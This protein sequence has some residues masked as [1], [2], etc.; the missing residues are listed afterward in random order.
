MALDIR[1]I[2]GQSHR[3]LV[4]RLEGIISRLRSSDPD[5]EASLRVVEERPPTETPADEPLVRAMAAAYR[6]LTGREPR[7]NGV[8]GATDGTFL[9]EWAGIPVVTTGAGLREIPHHAD[10]WVGLEELY[11]TCRLYAASA[12]YYCF[13]EGG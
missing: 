8:P 2:P 6:R 13:E 3:E 7:Y 4:G 10:E 5:F 9:H 1:T 12:L 11:E